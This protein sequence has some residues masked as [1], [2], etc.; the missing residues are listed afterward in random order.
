MTNKDIVQKALTTLLETGDAAGLAPF[1]SDDFVHH[2]PGLPDRDKTEWLAAVAAS[3]GPT[4]GL[5][6]E[7]EHFLADGDC[8]I[9]HSR[10]GLPAGPAIAVAEI[11]RVRDAR[12]TEGWELI[13]PVAQAAANL[14]WWEAATG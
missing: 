6:V 1:L 8:V 3:L 13:E 7:I 2:R 12:V 10:R 14:R 9:M 4:A 5:Q 11:W